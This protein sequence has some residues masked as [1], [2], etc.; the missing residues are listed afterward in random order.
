MLRDVATALTDLAAR[1][2]PVVHRDLKPANV[3]LLDR[4]WCL[5]DFGI[6][7]YA[8]ASTAP[9]TRKHAMSAAYAAPER[10]RG[11][12]ATAAADVY[13][14]GVMAFELLTGA[15]PFL[16]PGWEDFHDQHLHDDPPPLTGASP[17]LAAL[18]A[19]CLQKAPQ[20]RPAPASL[21][22]RLGRAA[23][24]E[25]TPGAEALAAA[26]Q[27][28]VGDAAAEAAVASRARTEQRRREELTTAAS[29]TSTQSP[30][31]CSRLCST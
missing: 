23:S 22:A 31:S 9:D 19:E 30:S 29:Q 6:S 8:E 4:T 14:V 13:A 1:K 18:V 26:F 28:Q 15:R 3:L 17:R 12:R 27:R 21:L 20:A 7:R 2:K 24:G 5:A 10:W 16:G 11:D 25:Q